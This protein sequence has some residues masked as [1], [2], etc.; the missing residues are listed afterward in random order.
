MANNGRSVDPAVES[1]YLLPTMNGK[2]LLTW[3]LVSFLGCATID[4]VGN[5][6]Y[7]DDASADYESGQVALR[8]GRPLDAIRYFDHVRVRYPYSAEAA[9]S[10]LAIGDAHFVQEKYLEAI[11]A[12]QNFLKLHPNHPRADYASFRMALSSYKDM[13]SNFILF[14]PSEEKD[15]TTVRQAQQSLE[16]FLH[17]Y[18]QSKWAK[19][20]AQYL[21]DVKNR[22]AQH[23][24]SIAQFYLHRDQWRAAIGRLERL[25]ADYPSSKLEV[26]ALWQLAQAHLKLGDRNKAR[27]ALRRIV[28]KYPQD[29][30]YSKAKRLLQSLA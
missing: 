6:E 19:E 3:M 15:Q 8:E 25:L 17:Q 27:D 21:A 28:E 22:L 26:E 9:L 7:A 24:M 5:L 14:P 10:D 20:A 16:Q 11:S 18:P 1:R 23:E 29:S 4:Q 2:T 12:Y 13:P 30:R